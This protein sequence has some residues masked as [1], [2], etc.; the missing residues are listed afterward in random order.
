MSWRRPSDE[1]AVALS[2]LDLLSCGLG[3]AALLFLVFSTVN[4]GVINADESSVFGSVGTGWQSF[5]DS[6]PLEVIVRLEDVIE[7]GDLCWTGIEH[8]RV[9]EE[10]ASCAAVPADSEPRSEFSLILP[11]GLPLRAFG[12]RFRR[13]AALVADA[14]VTILA[15]SG[16]DQ[17]EHQ[18]QIQVAGNERAISI[19]PR[20]WP[21]V[22]R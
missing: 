8:L 9:I 22:T 20:L 2:F 12:V 16:W 5:G 14:G 7:A 3:A 13:T 18:P 1:N 19:N 10:S 15:R 4:R 21:A 11:D 17:R 6:A